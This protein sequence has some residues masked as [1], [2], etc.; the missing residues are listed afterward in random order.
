MTTETIRVSD[1]RDVLAVIPA[2]LGFQPSRS[3]VVVRL[4][5]F[6]GVAGACV[7]RAGG[8]RVG[9]VLGVG[10]PRGWRFLHR[11]TRKTPTCPT[12]PSRALT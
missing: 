7:R 8:W 9:A 1:D 10:V 12:L 3:L 11:S 5:R 2:L 6:E 4:F